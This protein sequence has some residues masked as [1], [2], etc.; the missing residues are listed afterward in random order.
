[1]LIVKAITEGE[2]MH[3]NNTKAHYLKQH[4]RRETR[5]SRRA[6]DGSGSLPC[7]A[8]TF[9]RVPVAAA[10]A[11]GPHGGLAS[12][13]SKCYLR[14]GLRPSPDKHWLQRNPQGKARA[15]FGGSSLLCRPAGRKR[16]IGIF[17]RPEAF[18]FLDIEQHFGVVSVG[19][20]FLRLVQQALGKVCGPFPAVLSVL[21]HLFDLCL[22]FF[23]GLAQRT[24]FGV[25]AFE[26]GLPSCVAGGLSQSGAVPS[27]ARR[28][29]AMGHPRKPGPSARRF[30]HG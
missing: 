27:G 15:G 7:R 22:K 4:L 19:S 29:A 8:G 24:P 10:S 25:D 21:R 11:P 6:P 20:L 3:A 9:R 5:G 1:M 16:F 30:D 23:D 13:T 26:K 12:S 17:R 18:D 28:L 14:F 2:G